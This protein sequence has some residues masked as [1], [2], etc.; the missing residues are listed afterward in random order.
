MFY[1]HTFLARKGP[2]G[3]VWCAAHLQHSLRKT[4][5]TRTNILS[6][7][8]CI[9]Y[10]EVPIALRM[11]GHLLLGVVR[12]YSKQV[13]YFFQEC[14]YLELRLRKAFLSTS[15]NLPE[16]AT[17][18]TYNSITLPETF[19]LDALQSD[20]DLRAE[21]FVDT[22]LKPLEEIT[23]EEQVPMGGDQYVAIYI[24][25]DE[26]RGLSTENIVSG[27]EATPMEI[28]PQPPVGEGTPGGPQHSPQSTPAQEFP[29]TEV[30]R[31]ASHDVGVPSTP[32]W[33][34]RRDDVLEPDLVLAE[35]VTK[36]D[37]NRSPVGVVEEMLP[38]GGRSSPPQ[39]R[40]HPS[41]SAE[42]GQGNTSSP[43]SF[44]NG[45]PELAMRPS[46]PPP[47]PPPEQRPARQRKRKVVI[48]EALVLSNQVLKAGL[49]DT[50]RLKR[51]RKEVPH[52]S[53]G[54]WRSSK[55]LKK[56]A[57]FFFEPLITGQCG[58]LSNMHEKDFVFARAHP[59]STDEAR[60]EATGAQSSSPSGR[61]DME[62]EHLRENVGPTE[63][64]IL[65]EVLPMPST[66]V[67]SPVTS[68][69]SPSR[70]EDF[71]PAPTS[72]GPQS[73]QAERTIDSGILPTPDPAASTGHL[74]SDM[75][76]PLTIPEED[77]RFEA[78]ALSDIPEFDNSAG[79]LSFL[80][81]DESTP[82]GS[83]GTP[84]VGLSGKQRTPEFDALST[85]TRA[86]AQYLKGQSSTTPISEGQSPASTM[87][88][89]GDL[90]LNA[91]LEGKTRK[92]CARMFFE[93]LVLKNCGLI[94][95][96]QEEPYGD[97]CRIQKA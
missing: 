48:D 89:P 1:S 91:V 84:E 11:S 54:I 74:H 41:A 69:P 32:M 46:P 43:L 24:D 61:D 92:I 66:L 82:T 81:Q 87:P 45:S 67:S 59:S 21:R 36:D 80:E 65:H 10:P 27:L 29:E 95:V 44:G 33:Q 72:L 53:L 77:L 18:A 34:D 60:E 38:S 64:D 20:Y 68:L 97:K 39:H 37:Q 14:N 86:V 47:P 15:V 5:Y 40:E 22:H 51:A 96:K 70:Q 8:E 2:M 28:D 58:E 13:E 55:R 85:R 76:T 26:G 73:D 4:D 57:M 7:V 71:T 52:S 90:S 49:N 19:Q 23:L 62:I 79:D 12:I 17:Q 42:V 31:D 75:D 63:G 9:M 3:T 56:D 6:T 88:G 78:T 30:M 94:D 93:T 16:G 25:E 83:Q 35:Q 50:S